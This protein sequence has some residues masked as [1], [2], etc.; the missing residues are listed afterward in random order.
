M[1]RSEYFGAGQPRRVRAP[2]GLARGL[3]S[4]LELNLMWGVRFRFRFSIV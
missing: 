2:R 4:Y 1:G 3:Q